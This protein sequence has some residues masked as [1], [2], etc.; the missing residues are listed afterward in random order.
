MK[1]SSESTDPVVE[2]GRAIARGMEEIRAQKEK[3]EAR[4]E[5]RFNTR[6]RNAADKEMFK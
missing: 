1:S 5:K 2:Q 6:L 4:S 3:N